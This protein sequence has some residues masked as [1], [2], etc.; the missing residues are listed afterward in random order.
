MEREFVEISDKGEFWKM[1][2]EGFMGDGMQGD[3][4]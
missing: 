4:C 2:R 3:V 1:L